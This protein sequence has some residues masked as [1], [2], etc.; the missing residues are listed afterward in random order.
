MAELLMAL[1]LDDQHPGTGE[2]LANVAI[3]LFRLADRLCLSLLEEVDLKMQ[4]NRQS[5]WVV[6][7]DGVGHRVKS[8]L[9]VL[10]ACWWQGV[11]HQKDSS[12]SVH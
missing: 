11:P 10:S 2:E 6:D 1:T 12:G 7:A 5:G 4:V 8:R 9:G 3:G